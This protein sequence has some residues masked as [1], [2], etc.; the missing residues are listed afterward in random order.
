MSS[1]ER[2]LRGLPALKRTERSPGPDASSVLAQTAGARKRKPTVKKAVKKP[3]RKTAG[4]AAKTKKRK[5]Q[6]APVPASIIAAAN[7]RLSFTAAKA[8]GKKKTTL[9]KR[10]SPRPLG[11]VGG[12]RKTRKK[13]RTA[14]I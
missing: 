8:L 6:L 13:R 4:V 3:V 12:R 5:R 7:R 2:Q 9:A 10:R 11:I 1:L 14:R